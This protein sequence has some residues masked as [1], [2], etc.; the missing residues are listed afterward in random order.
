MS[1]LMKN[2]NDYLPVK[3]SRTYTVEEVAKF[4]DCDFEG[5]ADHQINFVGSYHRTQNDM[6]C[7]S[8]RSVRSLDGVVIAAEALTGP[9][10]TIITKNPKLAMHKLLKHLF[11]ESKQDAGIHASALIDKTAVLAD[12]VSIGPCVVIGPHVKIA[13]GVVIGAHT[14]IKAGVSIGE[15]TKIDS[16]VY[17]DRKTTIGRC[18]TIS[19]HAVIGDAGFGFDMTPS[20]WEL[21]PQVA[22]VH[23]GDN[24]D[25]GPA[26]TIDRGALRDTT[27]E[28]GVKVDGHC[29]IA[30]GVRVG[31]ST[32]ISG[33]AGIAGSTQVG[34]DCIVAGGTA[35]GDN[36]TIC[37]NVVL[38][39]DSRVAQDIRLP[40]VYASGSSLMPE[41]VWHKYVSRTSKE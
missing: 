30:H 14:V 9:S 11:P 19:S 33:T 8:A 7:Y 13:N 12:E 1:S 17:I 24:V 41:D 20:G 36:L 23:I 26:V 27:L 3:L 35:V 4:L 6:I 16:H 5:R 15:G 39:G 37:D 2:A 38:A 34:E 18:C 21:F 10:A 29:V 40:G 25:I 32:I 22:N 31:K 28:D